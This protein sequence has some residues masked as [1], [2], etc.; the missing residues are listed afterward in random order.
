VAVGYLLLQISTN[1]MMGPSHGL[2]PDGVREGHRGLAVGLRSLLDMLGIV[3][4]AAFSGY[5][6]HHA[7][8]DAPVGLIVAAGVLL[9]GTLLTTFGS[10]LS[11]TTNAPARPRRRPTIAVG[12]VREM[13]DVDMNEHPGYLRLLI[14]RFWLLLA[15]SM[16]LSFG[17]Y[18]FQDA[19]E[20]DNPAGAVSNLMASIGIPMG[21]VVLPAGILS[22][23][24]GRKGL[25]MAACITMAVCISLLS[26][27]RTVPAIRIVG[28]MAGLGMGTFV[29]VNWA[30]ATDLAPLDQAGKYLG[31][32]NLATAGTSA[33]GRLMGPVIDLVN[34]WR[35][36]VGYTLV[37]VLA[38]ASIL[39]ALYY[40]L[41]IPETRGRNC[42]SAPGAF[43]LPLDPHLSGDHL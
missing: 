35:D 41:H 22:E 38:G 15:T 11:Q 2:I 34:A 17:F 25:T 31:L 36:N 42:A 32:A 33:I 19:L 10:R 9:A 27:V 4:A 39:T 30:W 18:Y 37:F 8:A 23:R 13:L 28:L 20:V 26:M 7:G 14:S 6:A 1:A 12:Q 16:V 5:L 21:L 24:W 29:S 3:A 43:T 40:T